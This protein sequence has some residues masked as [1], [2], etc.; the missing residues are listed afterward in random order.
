ML[1]AIVFDYG[2]MV[3]YP[4]DSMRYERMAAICGLDRR[5]MYRMYQ[6]LRPAYDRGKFGGAEYWRRIA[7]SAGRILTDAQVDQ[8][9]QEDTR[10]TTEL[11][12]EMLNWVTRLVEA[13]F[14]AGILSNMT[15]DD[16]EK[17][18]RYRIR[19][20]LESFN[21]QLFS[22]EIG[23]VKSEGAIY[24]CCL[25]ALGVPLSQV[26][27]I[28]VKRENVIAAR[29]SGMRATRFHSFAASVPALVRAYRLPGP[30]AHA[31]CDVVP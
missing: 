17:I 26:L 27:F 4:E 25:A 2:Q 22:S 28:D 10:N 13:G 1:K 21:V 9:V 12:P 18:A 8:L 16:M 30:T 24:R 11:N 5:P 31:S 29:R 20:R 14:A 3:S 23:M 6:A 7:A 19:E 15:I